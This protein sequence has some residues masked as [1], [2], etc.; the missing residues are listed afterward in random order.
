MTRVII[1]EKLKWKYLMTR[2][3]YGLDVQVTNS[4]K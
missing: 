1:L 4:V 3:G 2:L